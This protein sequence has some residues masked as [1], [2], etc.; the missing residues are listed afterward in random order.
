MGGPFTG[1]FRG[2][3]RD[4]PQ[5]LDLRGSGFVG[6]DDN[7]LAQLP[8]AGIGEQFGG[9]DPR[10][11]SRGLANGF[12]GALDY[13]F[14]RSGTRTSVNLGAAG[15]VQQF[16]SGSGNDPFRFYSYGVSAGLMTKITNRSS[17]GLSAATGFAPFYQY[18][19]FL[20]NTASEESPVSSDYGFA[21]NSEWVRS[22]SAGLSFSNQLSRRTSVN[23]GISWDKRF[24]PGEQEGG[25]DTRAAI[26]GISHALTRK[27]SFRFGYGLQEY[28]NGLAAGD[29]VRGQM[30]DIGLSYGDGLTLTFGRH[31]TL[32]MSA[33]A[34]IYK[35]GNPRLVLA[36][37]KSTAFAVNGAATLSRSIGRTWGTSIGYA[38]TTSYMVGFSD[39]ITLD[40]AN[41]GIGGPITERLHFSAGAGASRGQQ[42]FATSSGSLVAYTGSTR[43]SFALFSYLGLYA[44]ASYYKYSVPSGFSNFG[45]V[46]DLDR[47]SATVGLTTWLPLIKQRRPRTDSGQTTAGQP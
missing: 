5:T 33:S 45:F 13:G 4:Q 30:I 34:S 22:T 15:T 37:G 8:G 27:L 14:R 10:L 26:V 28:R 19:P 40:S 6:W 36:T 25:T 42:V 3:P 41:A 38:R 2:S 32:S 39:L 29:P 24:I 7:L 16:T 17:M 9:V 44:Q 43:L 1:L 20:K 31:Y 11:V 46:P 21:V 23:A 35:N 18:A 47:R 12:Q